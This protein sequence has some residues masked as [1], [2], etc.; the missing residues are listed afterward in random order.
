MKVQFQTV[1]W[2]IEKGLVGEESEA[3]GQKVTLKWAKAVFLKLC[4]M[5]C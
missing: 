1:K 2:F 4:C 3:D 5:K